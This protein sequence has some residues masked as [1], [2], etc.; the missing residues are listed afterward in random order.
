MTDDVNPIIEAIDAGHFRG[1]VTVE[2]AKK[3]SRVKAG[4][5]RCRACAEPVPCS[6]IL[7]ARAQN[8]RRLAARNRAELRRLSPAVAVR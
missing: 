2:M 5:E 7:A 4:E 8:A 3:D 6:T 1:I